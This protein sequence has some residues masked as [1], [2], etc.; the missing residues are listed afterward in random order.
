MER[1]WCFQILE[2]TLEDSVI[3]DLI[4]PAREIADMSAA[5]ANSCGLRLLGIRPVTLVTRNSPT[6]IRRLFA[7]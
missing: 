6:C 4:A 3:G 1:R 2:Q 5:A 7:I